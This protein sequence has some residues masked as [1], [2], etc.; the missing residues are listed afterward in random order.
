MLDRLSQIKDKRR[1][2]VLGMIQDCAD[3]LM[4]YAD[5]REQPGSRLGHPV[6]LCGAGLLSAV[7]SMRKTWRGC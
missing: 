5:L 2:E 7:I 4:A 1:D 6:T 3:G